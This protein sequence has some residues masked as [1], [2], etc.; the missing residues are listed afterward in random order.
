MKILVSTDKFKGTL[1]AAEAG[2]AIA[3]GLR[4]SNRSTEVRLHPLA[5]GGDGTLECFLAGGAA[6]IECR[7]H[8]PLMRPVQA[9]YAL[10]PDGLTACI[11]MAKASGLVLLR[12]EE[13]NPLRTTSLGT[14]ELIRDAISRGVRHVLLGI[15]GS[16][17]NDGGAGM[18]AAL[19][20][21]FLDKAGD[22]MFPC[23]GSLSRMAEVDERNLLPEL[24]ATTFTALCDVTNPF[25]GEH[26]AAR[27]YAPQK[28]A[29]EDDV[30]VLDAGLQHLA[31]WILRTKGIDLQ[32][33]PGAGA[34]GGLAGGAVAWL[35]AKLRS[36][37]DTVMEQ[38]HYD[39]ALQWAD[40]V[41]TGEGKVDSQSVSGKVVAGVLRRVSQAGKRA[42]II[43][44]DAEPGI[45]WPDVPIYSMVSFAGSAR[46]LSRPA[47]CLED[48]AASVA[49]PG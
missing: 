41:V 32:R 40:I 23:G 44:G 35:G 38:T 8:D 34:G 45:T 39:R 33:V 20:A 37:I 12:K 16:A 19:G 43:C 49:L 11:E 29:S 3:R 4:R 30:R 7:V 46:S 27:V 15:G 48:V 42:I 9:S 5:D 21:R 14:G 6:R 47:E 24:Q 22:D 36:G 2:E 26:G 17:T 1:S 28:G 18:M 31:S 10:L 25:Y 13:L